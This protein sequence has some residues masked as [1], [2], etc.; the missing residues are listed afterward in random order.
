LSECARVCASGGWIELIETNAQL[1]GGSSAAEQYNYWVRNSFLADRLDVF[2]EKA[3]FVNVEK[4]VY[5]FPVGH[6]GGGAGQLFAQDFRLFNCSLKPLLA[7]VFNISDE[8]V[9]TNIENVMKELENH[10][11]YAEF[12]VYVGQKP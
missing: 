9:E 7:K 4:T 5:R 1:V 6:W 3:G 11:T 8:V 2:L 12:Y 10:H